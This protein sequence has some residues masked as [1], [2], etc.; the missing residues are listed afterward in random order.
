[1]VAT[2]ICDVLWD[3]NE[4]W[5]LWSEVVTCVFIVALFAV[6]MYI[7]CTATT[8]KEVPRSKSTY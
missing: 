6:E 7:K 5:L 1:M 3:Q 8:G 2:N 4:L